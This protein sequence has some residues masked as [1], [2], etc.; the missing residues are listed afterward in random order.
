MEQ[1]FG[2]VVRTPASLYQN[3][4]VLVPTPLLYQ[5]PT[6]APR[7]A[8]ADGSN[9]KSFSLTEKPGLSSELQALA[10]PSNPDCCGHLRS[11]LA[12]GTDSVSQI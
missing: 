7:E 1:M 12:K 9:S 11:E 8:G 4:W 3:A 10:L 6:N 5:F 2:L